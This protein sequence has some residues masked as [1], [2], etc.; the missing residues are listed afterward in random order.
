MPR[1]SQQKLKPLYVMRIL[2]ELSDEEHPLD[3]FDLIAELEKY[4]ISAERKSIYS[5]I[6]HLIE[7]GLDIVQ[8]RSPK[9]GWFLASREYEIP[10]VRLLM[11]AVQS[12]SF[13][14]P[15]KTRELL[16]KLE[17]EV[18]T[19]QASEFR[20]QAYFDP[21]SKSTNE[22]IYYI[23]D[24]IQR[25]ISKNK[26]V[27]FKYYRREVG[28]GRVARNKG[29]PVTVSPYAMIWSNNHYYLI[30]SLSTYNT[31]SH[32]RLDR[33]GNVIMT[34]K[35]IRSFE[36]VCEYRDVFD[37]ADYVSKTFSMFSGENTDVTLR[38]ENEALEEIYDRFGE[39][40]FIVKD[41]EQHFLAR[42]HANVSV[43]F[44]SWIIQFGTKIEVRSPDDLRKQV[45]DHIEQ[46]AAL[47]KD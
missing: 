8:T 22:E 42:V 30:C 19:Y 47:Y 41:D 12:A 40:V 10:E 21:R 18:S 31:L 44:L 38:C 6:E 2:S 37:V 1:F 39:D 34:E 5:D 17:L 29:R 16:G 3:S 13:I 46:M 33:M 4:S 32:Y 45:R 15:R 27:Q 36:E 7:F 14:T 11:D 23:M 43:G 20:Q 26:K 9:R 24:L 25:A 28:L 35:P